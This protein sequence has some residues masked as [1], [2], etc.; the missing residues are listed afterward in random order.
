MGHDPKLPTTLMQDPVFRLR[1]PDARLVLFTLWMHPSNHL[2]GLF[3]LD[4]DHLA[5]D[6][7]L[8]LE[9]ATSGLKELTDH[10]L[11]LRHA[12]LD[13][14]WLP[15]MSGLLGNLGNESAP[16]HKAVSRYVHGLVPSALCHGV[17]DTLSIPYR[18]G[19]DFPV[20][21]AWLPATVHMLRSLQHPIPYQIGYPIGFCQNQDQGQNQAQSQNQGTACRKRPHSGTF[22]QGRDRWP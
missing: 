9:R 6:V 2:S 18:Y 4:L 5:L 11:V 14:L 15:H 21:C 13:Q 7:R 20:L 8:P 1:T 19:S 3:V 22:R 17:L 16:V 10:G 12:P